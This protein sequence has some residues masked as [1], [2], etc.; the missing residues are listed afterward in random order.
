[1]SGHVHSHD[2]A[3]ADL[4][5]IQYADLRGER[6]LPESTLRLFARGRF[7]LACQNVGGHGGAATGAAAAAV[8]VGKP[9]AR[10]QR[11]LRQFVILRASIT[12]YNEHSV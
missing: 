2:K 6:K 7:G 4:L 9:I 1:M 8:V 11:V 12:T 10:T 5:H 3:P